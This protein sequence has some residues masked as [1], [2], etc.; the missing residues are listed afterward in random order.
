MTARLA[1][2][3]EIIGPGI[4]LA[5]ISDYRE[6]VVPLTVTSDELSAIKKLPDP[7]VG[8]LEGKNVKVAVNWINPVFDERT[9]KLSLELV[10]K[11]YQGEKRG[12]LK[13]AIPL[14]TKSEGLLI[15]KAAVLNRYENPKVTLKD[16][17]ESISIIV[18]GDS[19]DSLVIAENPK[20][21]PGMEL[22]QTNPTYI[23]R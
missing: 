17:G 22:T 10:I 19:G 20:L 7:F 3:G 8:K 16:T 13:L 21:F 2:E 4:P 6:L 18:I 15:P 5:R 14:H 9:R 23:K 11:N 12:G 1:N